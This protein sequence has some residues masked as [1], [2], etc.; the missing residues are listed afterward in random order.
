MAFSCRTDCR[1]RGRPNASLD[2][3][4]A[5][6]SRIRHVPA[7]RPTSTLRLNVL[8]VPHPLNRTQTVQLAEVR[9]QIKVFQV[10]AVFRR[11]AQRQALRRH[12]VNRMQVH[13]SV[14]ETHQIIGGEAQANI[15]ITSQQ[16]AAVGCGGKPA[17][18]HEF[19][20]MLNQ[21]CQEILKIG[22]ID[23]PSPF[24]G[25]APGL[26]HGRDPVCAPRL[27]CR[28]SPAS[29][30]YRCRTVGPRPT[31]SEAPRDPDVYLPL[32]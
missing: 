20:S 17:H 3:M 12:P 2:R 11:E 32:A 28:G 10:P 15:H 8:E 1:S 22:H 9:V 6:K 7:G 21:A 29:R 5:S 13:Q 25:P 16:G 19:H 18:Q 26:E 30:T 27:S 14:L 23:P 4:R 24:A 31:H